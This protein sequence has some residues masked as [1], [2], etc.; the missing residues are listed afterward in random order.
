MTIKHEFTIGLHLT[1]SSINPV[2]LADLKLYVTTLE[3][4]GMRDDEPLEE[5]A[6]SY[7]RTSDCYPAFTKNGHLELPK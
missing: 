1:S 7:Y 6:A 5:I 3:Q 4:I 2:T